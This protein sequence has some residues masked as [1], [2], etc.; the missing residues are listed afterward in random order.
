MDSNWDLEP[1][2]FSLASAIFRFT[3]L[4]GMAWAIRHHFNVDA[5]LNKCR[6]DVMQAIAKHEACEVSV[7]GEMN[8]ENMTLFLAENGRAYAAFEDI[9]VCEG[10]D[11][12]DLINGLCV[13]RRGVKLISLWWESDGGNSHFLFLQL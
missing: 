5:G 10:A 13:G 8:D 6:S 12:I 7:I 9:I 11:E 4:I 3:H 2:L 1:R